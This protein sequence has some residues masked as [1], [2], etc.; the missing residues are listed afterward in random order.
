MAETLLRRSETNS[1]QQ[2]LERAAGFPNA[3]LRLLDRRERPEWL[4]WSVVFEE[5]LQV[6]S[7]LRQIGMRRGETVP[8]VFPTDREFFIAF[9]GA[10][11]AG[12]VPV[13][14]Y[15]PV[16]LGRLEEYH[17]RTASMLESVRARVVLASPRIR[18]I[19]GSAIEL[20]DPELGCLVL[21]QLPR[22]KD[23]L[24]E[25]SPDDLAMVQF[26]SGTTVDPKPVALTHRAVMAQVEALNRYW[27]DKAGVHH[28]GVS[29]LPL[30]HDMG[31]IGCVF[32]AL[33]RPSILTLI[34]PEV[35][36]ARPASWLRAISRYRATVSPAPN[37]AYGL[38]VE[39]VS[40][41]EMEGVDLSC[42]KV[43]LNGAEPVAPSVLRAF[44]ERFSRWG[45]ES[46]ALTPVYGLSEACLAVTF[47]PIGRGFLSR[48]FERRALSDRGVAVADTDG[49]ELVSVGRPLPGFQISIRS[50]EGREMGEGQ[51]GRIWVQGPSLMK[52]YLHRPRSTEKTLRDGWLDTGDLGFRFEGELFVTGRAKDVLIVRGQNH[53]PEELERALSAVPGVRTG[54]V[55]AVSRLPEGAVTEEVWLFVEQSSSAPREAPRVLEEKCRR[56]VLK[57]S[58]VA[59]EQVVVVAPGTLPRTSSGKIRRAETL[60]RHLAA[61]LSPPDA[62]SPLTLTRS[63]WRSSRAF[64]RWRLRRRGGW[65]RG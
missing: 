63:W 15:P 34:P 7:G 45:F 61:E 42:W 4:S 8:L 52:E 19:L 60:R 53:A 24:P 28:T 2:V 10:L 44:A 38:C 6:A 40:D 36:V 16:R 21:E 46:R 26:S 43:A 58:G 41:E 20:A 14:L 1:L 32:P 59:A 49:L 54:C 23:L 62:V 17:V 55:A 37:F 5:S 47:S 64:Q 50:Q 3:G 13:P 31:L 35:F 57:A 11:L 27:P 33:E 39:K 65:Q 18:R 29:W 25:T 56:E 22:G 30:Y 12:T 9:F 48:R 51:V